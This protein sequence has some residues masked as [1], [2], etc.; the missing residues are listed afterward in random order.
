MYEVKRTSE[1]AV[2]DIVNC[3]G[4]RCE[5]VTPIQ[6]SK[7]HS[8]PGVFYTRALVTNRDEV[9]RDSVPF[10]WTRDDDG[11]HRWTIQGNDLAEWYVYA[12]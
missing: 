7:A 3:H 9:S 2:G 12:A 8:V 4:M 10:G 1:L 11:I 6:E 5:I